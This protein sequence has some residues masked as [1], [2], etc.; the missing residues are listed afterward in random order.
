[1]NVS[2]ARSVKVEGGGHGV[3]GHVGLHALA[4]FADAVRLPA[5]LS[6]A[7]PPAGERAPSHD[8]GV[9]LTHACL[10]LAGGGEA[11]GLDDGPARSTRCRAPTPTNCAPA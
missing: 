11:V 9:V 5:A 6:A 4:A 8:R 3:V 10:M 2:S 7:I 1:M